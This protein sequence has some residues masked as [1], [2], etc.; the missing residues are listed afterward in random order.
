MEK[1]TR[2]TLG[3]VVISIIYTI[4]IN[5]RRTTGQLTQYQSDSCDSSVNSCEMNTRLD[6]MNLMLEQLQQRI[7][8]LEQLK[9]SSLSKGNSWCHVCSG[10]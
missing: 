2:T 9:V 5:N 6:A 10:V 4:I 1:R 8:L 3:Y 7:T